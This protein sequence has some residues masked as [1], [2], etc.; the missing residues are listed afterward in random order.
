MAT[1]LCLAL[2]TN[3]VVTSVAFSPDGNY[4]VSGSWDKSVRVW[5]SATGVE[6]QQLNGHTNIVTSVAFSPDGN[7]IVSGSFDNSVCVWNSATGVKLQQLNG[8]INNVV[9]IQ[10][11]NI[12]EASSPSAKEGS[13][14][15]TLSTTLID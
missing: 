13:S 2:G 6:L 8:Q 14:D 1:T 15:Q 10:S 4:I 11:P 12:Q 9:S 5:N 3:H 7:Y